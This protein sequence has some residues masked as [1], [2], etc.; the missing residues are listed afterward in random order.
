MTDRA[1]YRS[2]SQ[3]EEFLHN[4][5]SL[6]QNARIHSDNH[7][8]VV[9]GIEKFYES[10]NNCLESE[11]LTVKISNQ[12]LYFNDEK[13]PYSTASK[14][15][16]DN[17]INYFDARGLEGL[18]FLEVIKDVNAEMILAF[19]RRLEISAQKPEPVI[20][21]TEALSAQNIKWVES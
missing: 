20:W 16:F 18:R 4:F 10:L 9:K 6:S 8:L 11:S 2:Y 21:L 13:L 5:Y 1:K 3:I 7:T 14:N 15:L 17:I 12:Q 19:L